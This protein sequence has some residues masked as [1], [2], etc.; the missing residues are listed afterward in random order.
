MVYVILFL[1]AAVVAA[2]IILL[3]VDDKRTQDK[4]NAS[5][6]ADEQRAIES[7][8]AEAAA[9]DEQQDA[10][11]QRPDEAE[12]ADVQEEPQPEDEP[13]TTT[14]RRYTD[15]TSEPDFPLA[16]APGVSRVVSA[17]ANE[18]AEEHSDPHESSE[19]EEMTAVA[20]S[21]PEDVQ[22]VEEESQEE[23]EPEVV[24]AEEVLGPVADEESKLPQEFSDD[25]DIDKQDADEGEAVEP[26]SADS[27]QVEEEEESEP[28]PAPEPL[29]DRAKRAL[30][31]PVLPGA[32]RRERKAWAESKGFEFF[33]HDSY[34]AE[35]WVRGAAASGAAPR[36]IVAGTAYGHEMLL[37][38][39]G[40]VNVMAVRTGMAS[41]VVID[42][43][44]DDVADESGSDDLIFCYELE[45]FS[46]YSTEVGVAERMV[47]E[48]VQV[49][50]EQLPDA[51]TAVWMESEW[52][53]AQTTKQS[54]IPDWEEMLA[55]LAL[56]ADAARVLPPRSQANQP[57]RVEDLDPSRE[58][59]PAPQPE[60]TGPK[61]VVPPREEV[62]RPDIQRPE[63]PL[64][65]PSRTRAENL[66]TVSHSALGA[67]EV[68]AI[69][70]GNE[71]PEQ[72]HTRARVPR[73]LRKPASI[74]KDSPAEPETDKDDPEK[75]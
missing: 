48:R 66:G 54:R 46:V 32:L 3:I 58:I 14:E 1:A 15:L 25:S 49:G 24:E 67:D 70:D 37:M 44:R 16:T 60:L 45:D 17:N 13:D 4:L 63:E 50:L 74:F 64:V 65:M 73:R 72:D 40:G 62:E 57:F 41:D 71:R 42:F 20:D 36:D 61:L 28:E 39:I 10:A 55:P 68:D 22:P 31:K 9:A 27:T 56:L 33:K 7:E 35:E 23:A 8:Q 29:K 6:S 59:P 11:Q 52:V 47:D 2:G 5:E 75:S 38:D 69:A 43:R 18:D 53:L 51:V 12:L 30:H 26:A 34:L 21:E 19:Q